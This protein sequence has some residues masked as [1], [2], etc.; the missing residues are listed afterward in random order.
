[1]SQF[2]SLKKKTDMAALWLCTALLLPYA[3][4]ATKSFVGFGVGFSLSEDYG[5]GYLTAM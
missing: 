1:M 5:Y 2:H 3:T 4:Q